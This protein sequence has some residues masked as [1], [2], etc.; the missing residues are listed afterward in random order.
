MID[1]NCSYCFGLGWVCENHPHLAW[2]DHSRGCRCGAGMPRECQRANR[3]EERDPP[4]GA[5]IGT[6][7]GTIDEVCVWN[8]ARSASEVST[9][10]HSGS[11]NPFGNSSCGFS[12]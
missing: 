11:G 3:V 8:R 6:I 12:Y 2:T 1:P 5:G 7:A 9:L 10:Y 4:H